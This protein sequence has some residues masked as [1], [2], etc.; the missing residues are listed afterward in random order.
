MVEVKMT[1]NKKYKDTVF[2]SIF[3]T[4]EKLLELY[5][6]IMRTN[7]KDWSAIIINTLED[8]LFMGMKNDVSFEI[9]GILV[10]IEHQSTINENMA[11]RMLMY[12]GCLYDKIINEEDPNAIY[13]TRSV[14][15]PN[16]EFIVLY[17]GKENF[18]K[19]KTLKL[20]TVFKNKGR[21]NLVDLEVRV[22]NINKGINSELESRSKTLADYTSFIAKVR[23]YEEK[24]P[25]EKAI[26]LAINYCI[27]NNILKEFLLKNASG[28]VSMLTREFDMDKA[29]EVARWEGI[30]K[31]LEKGLEKGQNYVL[32]LMAQGLSYEEIKKKIEK[33]KNN[34]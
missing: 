26:K 29:L 12:L 18:P 16:P 7:Y 32:E 1:V 3:N 8:V 33:V 10:L 22:I 30:E 27:D 25:I 21:K 23:E 13:K 19:E 28:V 24:N 5:N 11:A 15:L 4:K 34:A 2:R 31:G 17:N 20:S 6:A 14:E 9:Y